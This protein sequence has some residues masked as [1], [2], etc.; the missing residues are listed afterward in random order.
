MNVICMRPDRSL[1]DYL[2]SQQAHPKK[3]YMRSKKGSQDGHKRANWLSG[4]AL[5][6]INY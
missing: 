3:G 6:G 2:A 5:L 4:N 1:R